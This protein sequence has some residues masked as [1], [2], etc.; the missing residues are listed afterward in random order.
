MKIKYI[1]LSAFIM[2]SMAATNE[3]KATG[4]SN[5]PIVIQ[6]ADKSPYN[7]SREEVKAEIKTI[8]AEIC[9]IQEGAFQMMNYYWKTLALT[10]LTCCN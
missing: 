1:T 7:Y 5:P 6:N 10:H 2:M 3:S 8:I 9:G 4:V